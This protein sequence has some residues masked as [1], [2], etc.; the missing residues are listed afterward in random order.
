MGILIKGMKMP[1]NCFHCKM[2]YVYGD[3]DNAKLM[4]TI[5]AK[6]I[7]L[8]KSLDIMKNCPLVEIPPHDE[9]Q[10]DEMVHAN[11]IDDSGQQVLM[12]DD[13]AKGENW[14]ICSHCGAGMCIGAKYKTDKRYHPHFQSYCPNCG[15]KM[16]NAY[17]DV[18][19]Q[20]NE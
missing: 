2:G 12:E 10:E 17:D 16:D 6:V 11:W 18:K 19:E 7:P 15:A 3:V 13:I 9:E 1:K 8:G 14:K 5:T 4:C 20:E